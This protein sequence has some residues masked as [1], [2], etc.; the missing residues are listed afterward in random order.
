MQC[1]S[2]LCLHFVYLKFWKRE[3][4][5]EA[6]WSLSVCFLVVNGWANH[7]CFCVCLLP[8]LRP[9]CVRFPGPCSYFSHGHLFC[10]SACCLSVH[11][12]CV[13][14]PETHCCSCCSCL[15]VALLCSKSPPNVCSCLVSLF[16]SNF[17]LCI[18]H[19]ACFSFIDGEGLVLHQ[20]VFF[21]LLFSNV[22]NQ[23][24]LCGC[25][26][27]TLRVRAQQSLSRRARLTVRLESK[28][29]EVTSPSVL[30]EWCQ[31]IVCKYS[32]APVT[33]W[34]ASWSD[35]LAL[36]AIIHHHLPKAM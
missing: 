17:H 9:P 13:I 24:S 25:R 4:E 6:C 12:V 35:G 21:W 30:L 19:L 23:F 27:A 8:S 29:P 16:I 20:M 22:C 2:W 15:V 10:T 1:A 5:R 28:E 33:D 18:L 34:S 3:R 11:H 7:F 36:C 32:S 14:H 26:T 31:S